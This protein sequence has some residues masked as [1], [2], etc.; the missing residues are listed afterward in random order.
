MRDGAV[1]RICLA[2]TFR[3]LRHSSLVCTHGRRQW[4]PVRA[5]LT[6]IDS[7][8]RGAVPFFFSLFQVHRQHCRLPTDMFL[9]AVMPGVPFASV[10]VPPFCQASS[11]RFFASI[12]AKTYSP[13]AILYS[14][15]TLRDSCFDARSAW[16]LFLLLSSFFLI[17]HLSPPLQ[18]TPD[19]GFREPGVDCK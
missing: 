10:R 12:S 8:F 16:I 13:Y 19:F 4:R 7:A 14:P 5:S 2:R 9:C 18:T 1:F 6:V 11:S 17:S 15:A 3:P